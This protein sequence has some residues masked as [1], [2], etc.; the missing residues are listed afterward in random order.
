MANQNDSKN[1][2]QDAGSPMTSGSP[3][4]F[5]QEAPA[6]LTA[7]GDKAPPMPNAQTAR[8]Y[9]RMHDKGG[10]MLQVGETTDPN[11]NTRP[12]R[13]LV[14]AGEVLALDPK[15]ASQEG[16][17]EVDAN[18][19]PLQQRSGGVDSRQT[20]EASGFQKRG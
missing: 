10:A 14:T 8:R 12:A 3:E 1:K 6:H 17:T 2:Q 15:Y 9:F 18:G 4:Q 16:L 19:Q 20:T 11:G 13:R 7:Q 5:L